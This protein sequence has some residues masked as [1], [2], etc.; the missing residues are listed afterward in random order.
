MTEQ[1][2]DAPNYTQTPNSI[3]DHM[4][5]MG[6]SELKCCLAITRATF[7]WHRSKAQLSITVLEKMTGLSRQG[8]IDGTERMV[9]RGL[10]R[11]EYGDDNNTAIYVVNVVDYPPQVVDEVVNVVD[12]PSPEAVNVVDQE[13][14][15]VVDPNKERVNKENKQYKE[16]AVLSENSKP[17][18]YW[19]AIDDQLKMDMSKS[20]YS[21][22]LSDAEFIGVED[23]QILIRV[24]DEH[25]VDKC[26]IQLLSTVNRIL[27]GITYGKENQPTVVKFVSMSEVPV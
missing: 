24:R 25:I 20:S 27:K 16:T 17:L 15:N 9:Q 13:V 19:L 18:Q 22:M 1:G 26:N 12:Y 5:S 6:L 11:K 8:V 2:F 23:D 4:K 14:V 7:G 10:V 3:F 21:W